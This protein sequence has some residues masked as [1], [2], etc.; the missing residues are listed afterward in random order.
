M[1]DCLKGRFHRRR[2][3][4]RAAD[5]SHSRFARRS[6]VSGEV[7]ILPDDRYIAIEALFLPFP[8]LKS[9]LLI[10][11]FI[12]EQQ[13]TRPEKKMSG[14]LIPALKSPLIQSTDNQNVFL[15]PVF[16]FQ[17]SEPTT[18]CSRYLHYSLSTVFSSVRDK[19]FSLA[20][21]SASM[22]TSPMSLTITATFNPSLL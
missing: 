21:N 17:T 7:K 9:I 1:T 19:V 22:F 3:R 18:M 10:I 14:P 8:F 11:K 6:N 15:W 12:V 2:L 20:T 5:R 4:N 16:P 13:L